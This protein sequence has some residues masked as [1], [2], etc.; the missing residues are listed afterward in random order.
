MCL[1]LIGWCE[2]KYFTEYIWTKVDI[3]LLGFIEMVM[4]GCMFHFS[5]TFSLL[6]LVHVATSR[7]T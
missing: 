7:Q 3:P 6:L 4:A 5:F 2:H 1:F